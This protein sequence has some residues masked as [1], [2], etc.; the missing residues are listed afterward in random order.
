MR[1]KRDRCPVNAKVDRCIVAGDVGHNRSV[2]R[3]TP[4]WI[5]ASSRVMLLTTGHVRSKSLM[6]VVYRGQ[7][8][9]TRY[10]DSLRPL[11][12][13]SMTVVAF[14]IFAEWWVQGS[15]LYY[16]YGVYHRDQVAGS[17]AGA[18]PPCPEARPAVRL[19]PQRARRAPVARVK[20]PVLHQEVRV[21]Q[22]G[23]V[24]GGQHH[25]VHGV[26]CRLVPSRG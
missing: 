20:R 19:S 21:V 15:G 22:R 9:N 17:R 13:Q 12:Y 2:A 16:M 6:R 24:H 1:D 10:V 8:R 14:E 26:A 23:S 18:R 5:D 11:E 25:G 4:R 7:G 3:S